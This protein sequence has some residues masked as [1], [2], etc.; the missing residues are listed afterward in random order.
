MEYEEAWALQQKLQDRLITNKRSDSPK[1][2]PHVCLLIEHPPVFTLGKSGDAS[3]LLANEA[4]LKSHGATFVKIDRG[5]DI[6]YHGPGQI[7][8]YPILDLDHFYTDIHRYLRDLE[9]VIIRTC[10]DYNIT[11]DRFED[12]TGVWITGTPGSERKICAMG[13][14][15]SRWVTMHGFALNMATK[16][17]HFSMI[18]PC[19][20]DDRGVTSMEM[21]KLEQ[22]ERSEVE[23]RIMNHFANVFD[24]RVE[25]LE[26]NDAKAF[27]EVYL[28]A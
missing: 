3:N 16:L 9:D 14:R 17:D 15:C 1:S 6:T 5:G 10:A 24:A 25:M 23:N 28:G 8:G 21:E 13:I 2:I 18:V 4:E 11:A 22:L 7:V 20:I 19:G 12:R 26:R 27:L